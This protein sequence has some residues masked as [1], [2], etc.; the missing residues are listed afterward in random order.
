MSGGVGDAG[1]VSY[2]SYQM[3]SKTTIK[4]NDGKTKTIIGGRVKEFIDSSEFKW[5]AEFKDLTPGSAKFSE[6]WKSVVDREGVAFKKAEHDFIKRTHYD[7]T[8]NNTIDVHKIDLRKNSKTLNDVIWS[9]SVHNGP[10]NPIIN[11]AISKMGISYKN[12]KD[13]DEKLIEE[14]YK[15]RG[16]I[17]ADGNLAYFSKNSKKVQAGVAGRFISEKSKALKELKNEK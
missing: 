14:I 5:G 11:K 13:Y 9:T 4:G 16:K 12:S 10:K 17:R 7:V 2:G 15:E 6:K 3:T 8:I 1:G